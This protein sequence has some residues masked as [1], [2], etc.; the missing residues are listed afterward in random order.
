MPSI[1]ATDSTRRSR[2]PCCEV[3]RPGLAVQRRTMMPRATIIS[4]STLIALTAGCGSDESTPGEADPGTDLVLHTTAVTL[5]PGDERYLC[6]ALEVP[7]DGVFPLSGI[8]FDVSDAFH[9]Y[10]LAIGSE[11][12]AEQ[13]YDC[14]FE[15]GA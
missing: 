9:H 14:G 11:A 15:G 2:S 1:V 6:W 10:Q 13:P 7:S 3:R 12:P 8:D 4:L 5:E